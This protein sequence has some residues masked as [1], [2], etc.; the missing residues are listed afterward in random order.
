MSMTE[1]EK[2]KLYFTR[3]LDIFEMHEENRDLREKPALEESM[4]L[5]KFMPSSPIQC[6]RNGRGKLKVIRGHSRLDYA[7]RL[8]L[9][10]WYVI[11]QTVTDL[12]ELEGDAGSRW[13]IEDFL[14]SRAKAGNEHYRRDIAFRKEH[15]ISLGAAISLMAGESAGSLNAVRKVKQGTFRVSNDLEHA[16]VVVS[17]VDFCR[18]HGAACA[19]T[20]GFVNALSAVARVPEFEPAVFRNRI[21]KMP[22]LLAKQ[23]TTKSYLDIIEEVYNYQAKGRRL[24]LAFRAVEVGR[25]R[26]ETFGG[27]GALGRE[28]ATEARTATGKRPA[29]SAHRAAQ[30]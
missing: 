25:Q 28:R 15:G 20:S 30:A 18:A 16:N 3:D 14:V 29:T 9:G 19:G 13:S 8:G 6:T 7:K 10:V 4:R 23:A 22:S 11:D 21:A 2:P 5:H 17:L 26:K 27:K 24:P 1:H 12:F